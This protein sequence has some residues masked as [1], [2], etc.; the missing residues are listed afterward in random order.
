MYALNSGYFRRILV[1]WKAVVTEEDMRKKKAK[2]R[3]EVVLE[4]I[5][6]ALLATKFLLRGVRFDGAYIILRAFL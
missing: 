3:R 2:M 5:I 6:F 1:M 4:L